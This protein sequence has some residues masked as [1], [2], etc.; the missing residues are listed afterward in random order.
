MQRMNEP[1]PA[2]PFFRSRIQYDC[3]GATGVRRSEPANLAESASGAMP[4]I[5]RITAV[6]AA[7]LD[8]EMEVTSDRL[9][10]ADN[11]PMEG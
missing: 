11:R 5:S 4:S 7:A 2:P 9:L 3:V 1:D 10:S 6:I 8:H